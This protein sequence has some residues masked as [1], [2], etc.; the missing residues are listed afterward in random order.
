MACGDWVGK[1]GGLIGKWLPGG[2]VH[3]KAGAR[4][5]IVD[6]RACYSKRSL[7]TIEEGG[8]YVQARTDAGVDCMADDAALLPIKR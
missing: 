8:R 7:D 3:S 6:A 4:A 1:V 5:L 2:D